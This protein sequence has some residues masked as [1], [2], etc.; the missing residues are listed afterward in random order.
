LREIFHKGIS[1]T[2][3]W[4]QGGVTMVKVKVKNLTKIFKKGKN[5]VVANDKISLEVDDGATFGILGESGGG[6]TTLL[7]Q[8]AGLE[9]PTDGYIYFDEKVVSA[10]NKI[11]VEPENRNLSLVFQNWALYPN[12][13]IYDNI[14]F[15]LRNIKM[16]KSE[17][18]KRVIEISETLNIKQ[19][20]KHYPREVSGGQMQRAA[21]ARA[22]VKNPSLLL[23]DEPFSNLDAQIR[24]S[25][26]ALVRKIQK[27]LNLTTIIVSHDP[28]DIFSIAEDA[29]V[30][31]RGKFVQIGNVSELYNNP[32]SETVSK[33][34]GD[35]NIV[36]G[37]VKGKTIVI[38]NLAIPFDKKIDLTEVKVGV[39]PE[40]M[41]ISQ[42]ETIKNYVNI[43]KVKVKVSSYSAGIFKLIVS[44][45][46]NESI[47]FSV[48]SETHIRPG[49]EA[50]LFIRPEKMK[51][52]DSNGNRIM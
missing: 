11:I 14:A 51:L 35:I 27:E 12:M 15:P 8:I 10:P 44:P 41:R 45:I 9:V 42:T 30:I 52:F 18:D 36:E 22:L 31:V 48:N 49:I 26:R 1:C 43:G 5:I 25:A 39:R 6:K 33:L 17:I 13:T 4:S 21:L 46:S 19:V 20:L 32:I 37:E 2:R 28:A 16:P 50:F 23:L 38:G 47:E 40:D 24:D 29:G 7:R 34:L 3:R